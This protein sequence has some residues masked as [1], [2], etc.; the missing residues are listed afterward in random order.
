VNLS[1]ESEMGPRNVVRP[2]FARRSVLIDY[3]LG[4]GEA[5]AQGPHPASDPLTPAQ[6]ELF[7]FWVTI[8]AQ[9]R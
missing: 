9:Y 4:V 8:G 2:A 6:Q 7:N 5:A 3:V 1:G